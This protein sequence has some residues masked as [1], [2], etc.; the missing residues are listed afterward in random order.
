MQAFFMS[1]DVDASQAQDLFELLDAD[2]RGYLDFQEFLSGCLR[3]QGEPRAVDLLLVA[4]ESRAA[5]AKQEKVLKDVL[6]HLRDFAP[7]PTDQPVAAQ[8][9]SQRSLYFKPTNVSEMPRTGIQY[10]LCT[11]GNA[12]ETV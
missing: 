7:M 5:F 9:T 2:G 8:L 6:E 11:N 3:L 12:A 4:K 10:A 1:I